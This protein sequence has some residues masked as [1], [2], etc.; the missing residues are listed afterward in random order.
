MLGCSAG[1]NPRN[2]T[3]DGFHGI[4]YADMVEDEE[5]GYVY[6][7]GG[8]GTYTSKH[9]PMAY[10]APEANRTFFCYG[11]TDS[12][13]SG[14]LQMA[15]YFDH[16]KGFV[17]RPT[18]V[19]DKRTGDA[20]DNASLMLDGDGHVWVFAA[21]HGQTRPSHIYRSVKPYSTEA[22]ESV[23]EGNFSYPQPWHIPGRGF[24]FL[25]TRYIDGR[26]LYIMTSPDGY[27]WSEP[28]PLSQI[29]QGQYQ[30]SWRIGERIGTA[31]NM[32]PDADSGNWDN[33][34]QAGAN[35][36][37]S[38]ANR[39]S[40][41][42]YMET[43]DMGD[44]WTTASGDTQAIPLVSRGNPALVHDYLSEEL[45]VYVKDIAFD[46]RGYPVILYVTSRGP[47]SGP[48]NGPRT[49][50]TAAWD[51]SEWR[52]GDITSS[53]NNYDMGSLYIGEN[54]EWTVIAP[55]TGG[56]Q[57]YNSGGEVVLWR[58]TD[59]GNTW[60]DHALTGGSVYNHSYVRKPVNAHDGFFAFWADG[61]GRVPSPSRLYFY[62]RQ[63]DTVYRLPAH[64]TG[65]TARPIVVKGEE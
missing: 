18:I 8:M 23:Y 20:H 15:A 64:M 40:N 51:G 39:R 22:F 48:E 59:R 60:R 7:S 49:W 5:Y 41:L 52:I 46:K 56:P 36:A 30:V 38:G 1:E 28:R 29:E 4:W 63:S 24:L 61:H 53:D 14:L 31:F 65:K 37:K 54:G 11:G 50:H 27:T 62:D 44:T 57:A 10:Y 45:L 47:E 9:V 25:H 55:T 33:P 21:S 3:V 6:Y 2:P 16:T 43:A 26:H 17:S 32:H 35:H 58:S 12:Q 19:V 42:Y 13:S 34:E